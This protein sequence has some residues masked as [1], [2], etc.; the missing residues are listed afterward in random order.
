MEKQQDKASV[1]QHEKKPKVVLVKKRSLK[2]RLTLFLVKWLIILF[3]F[4]A[5][6][7]AGTMVGFGLIGGEDWKLVLEWDTWKHIYNLVF[8]N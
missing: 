1:V 7:V 3:S 8:G 4:F 2:Q 5:A 6:V